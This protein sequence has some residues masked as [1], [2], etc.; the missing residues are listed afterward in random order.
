MRKKQL[1]FQLSLSEMDELAIPKPIQDYL[2][3]TFKGQIKL[4]TK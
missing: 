1:E 4:S 3:T 2:N